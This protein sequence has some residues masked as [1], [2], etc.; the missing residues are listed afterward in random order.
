MAK[1]FVNLENVWPIWD[2]IDELYLRKKDVDGNVKNESMLDLGEIIKDGDINI[3]NHLPVNINQI[4]YSE[5][6]EPILDENGITQYFDITSFINGF[7]S[8]KYIKD[9]HNVYSI[10]GE[11]KNDNSLTEYEDDDTPLTEIVS[12]TDKLLISFNNSLYFLWAIELG[13]DEG[14]SG[15]LGTYKI[16]QEVFIDSITEDFINKLH[17][18]G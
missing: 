18:Y 10:I 7:S 12:Q 17:N 8:R 9:D 4:M 3:S 16:I 13:T 6:G 14:G 11:I 2:K 15:G 5:G 1:R